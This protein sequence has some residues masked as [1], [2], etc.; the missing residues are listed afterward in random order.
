M[1]EVTSLENKLYEQF[2]RV[3]SDPDSFERQFYTELE[4]R[5]FSKPDEE[6]V[7]VYCNMQILTQFNPDYWKASLKE[8]FVNDDNNAKRIIVY[9][10]DVLSIEAAKYTIDYLHSSTLTLRCNNMLSHDD[11]KK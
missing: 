11:Q 8:E 5:S 1:A 4:L 10:P 3:N 6:G 7:K 2:L 9:Y